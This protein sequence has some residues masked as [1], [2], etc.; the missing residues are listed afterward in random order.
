MPQ[1][2]HGSS[3][4]TY[5]YE[6][7]HAINDYASSSIS[8]VNSVPQATVSPEVSVGHHEDGEGGLDEKWVSY[9]WLLGSIFQDI[10]N[11][12]LESASETLLKVT[13]WLLSQVSDL[14]LCF[15]GPL[16]KQD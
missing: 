16:W 3:G 13:Q 14:G 9:K 2:A 12:S 7:S 6:P 10:V 15:A 1:L 4:F 11:G 8:N 5:I